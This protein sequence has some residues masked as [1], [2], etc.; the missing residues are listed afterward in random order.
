MRAGRHHGSLV[1]VEGTIELS[2]A[3]AGRRRLM[4]DWRRKLRVMV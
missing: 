4:R 1:E 2:W 3:S